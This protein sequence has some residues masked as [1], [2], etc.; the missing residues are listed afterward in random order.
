MRKRIFL[1][2]FFLVFMAV[3]AQAQNQV[4]VLTED[5]EGGGIP[6][7]WTVVDADGDGYNWNHSTLYPV[8][9]YVVPGHNSSGSLYSESFG[10]ATMSSLTPDNWLISPS[11]SLSGSSTLTYWVKIPDPYYTG[12]HYG[13]YVSTAV[14]PT[15]SDFTLLMEESLPATVEEWTMRTIL[16][17]DYA[18]QTVHIAFRHFNCS[19]QFFVLLDDVTVTTST[20]AQSLVVSPTSVNFGTV[21]VGTLSTVESVG[22]SSYNIT[23][24][25]AAIVTPPF[26]ISADGSQFGATLSMPDT[27][28]TFYVR[29]LPVTVGVDSGTVTI[30]AGTQI[31]T[32]TLYGTGMDCNNITLPFEDGF[33]AAE[34]NPCWTVITSDP[35]NPTLYG[36]SDQYSAGGYKSLMLLPL[37]ATTTPYDLYLITP[38][39]PVSGMKAVSFDHRGYWSTETFVVGYSTTTNDISAFTWGETVSSPA[40][41]TTWN[42]YLNVS[43]PGNA[44]YVAVHHTSSGGIALMLDNFMVEETSSCMAPLNL[45]VTNITPYSADLSWY[46]TSDIIDVT[47]YYVTGSDTNINEIPSVFLTDGVYTFSGLTPGDQYSW[48][49]GV[50]CDGDTLFSEVSTFA[51]P[52]EPIDTLP[53]VQDFDSVAV[54]SIPDCWMQLNPNNGFPKVTTSHALSGKALEFRC[55]Y[56]TDEPV[57]AVMPQFATDLSELQVSFWTRREG[58]S[59]GTLKVGYLTDLHDTASFVPVASFSSAQ[60][61]DNN[62][63][64]Y[65]VPF[66]DVVAAAGTVCYIA[67]KYETTANWFWFLDDVTV[68]E[69]PD[70]MVPYDLT[71]IDVTDNSA[72][73]SWTGNTDSYRVYYKTNTDTSWM[74]L[75]NA[76]LDSLNG[77]TIPNL[78]PNTN[79]QW[80]VAAVCSDSTTVNSNATST[81]KTSCGVYA[82]PFSET[83]NAGSA[84][85]DCWVRYS[86][87]AD[88]TVSGTPLTSTTSGWSFSNTN[89]LGQHHASLH[90]YNTGCHY[91]L[92]T[93]NID[94]DG[95][96]NPMLTFDLALTDHDNASV[97]ENPTDQSDDKFMVLF[98]TDNGVSWSLDDAVIWSND[99]AT[100]DYPFNSIATTGQTVSISLNDYVGETVRIAFYGESTVSNGDND[101]HVDN[102]AIGEPPQCVAP[103]LLN[104]SNVT[105][106]TADISWTENGSATAWLVEYGPFYFDPG[107]GT[108]IM[109]SDTPFVM[110]TNLQDNT[111]YRVDVSALCLDGNHSSS[112]SQYFTTPLAPSAIPYSTDFSAMSD[113]N[114]LINNGSGLNWWT[115]GTPYGTNSSA[116]YVTCDYA[117]QPAQYNVSSTSVISAVK[118]L[119]VG[120]TEEVRISFDVNIGGEG[121]FDFI[122]LFFAPD[123]MHYPAN[124]TTYNVDYCMPSYSMFAYDFTDYLSYSTY[125]QYPFK[126]NLTDGNT[127]HIDAVMPNP[128]INPT[129]TSVAHLA[130]L[131]RNDFMSG[132]QPGAIISNL[133][134]TP[135]TCRKPL[136]LAVSS[137]TDS[138]A[139]ISWQ[140]GAA[141]SAWNIQYKTVTDTVWTTLSATMPTVTLIGL[142]PETDYNVR[143]QADCGA[144][145]VSVYSYTAFT[146]DTTVVPVILPTVVTGAATDIMQTT[147]TLHAT[148]TNPDNVTVSERGFKVTDVATGNQTTITVEGEGNVYSHDLTNLTPSTEYSVKAFITLSNDTIIYGDELN[149][150]TLPNQLPDTCARPTELQQI[151]MLKDG[152]SI[153]VCWTDNA[154]V[155]QWNLQYRP[156]NGDWVAVV[157]TGEPCYNITGLMD[158]AVYEIRVQAVCSADNLSEWSDVLTATASHSGF[159][160]HLMQRVFLYPNPAKEYIDIRVNDL[161]VKGMEVYDVYGKLINTVGVCDTPVQ[162]RINVSGLADGMYFVRVTTEEGV[163]TKTFVKR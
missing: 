123:T 22:V 141:E 49:L 136:N 48:M 112:V 129:S 105:T 97:V 21:N 81:F 155:N 5:F 37:Y 157:V 52:C 71:V 140:P 130:F 10:A 28:G 15:V 154:G 93:P 56:M 16:L 85:P 45:E 133:S 83:F 68:E 51:T 149:F 109:V 121:S 47:L 19:D 96:A 127:V 1:F 63:H 39:L 90:I 158:S 24:N 43:V 144:G 70:C 17:D 119:T 50:I 6:S 147:A 117:L 142:L 104:V 108:T 113:Q 114:W 100:A 62:Y 101:L 99:P 25:V 132:T 40:V 146:T 152:A 163:V 77:C 69:I 95:L 53:Y 124:S 73:V 31:R 3:F 134:V 67:F 57:F 2:G 7:G 118:Y 54:N 86:G 111:E 27:G 38:E 120:T 122:K 35:L 138:S 32:V 139:T 137:V 59:S 148:I 58:A 103:S 135:V 162:T 161:N 44:K 88:E 60:L 159:D 145:D 110:L 143:V 61:G 13:V 64:Y 14:N 26:E 12:E 41:E 107:T 23:G 91:W 87:L 115:M 75:D 116:L 106:S 126:F 94:L 151:I 153:N 156:Q 131:W 160:N 74:V 18:G 46:Q 66:S 30:T 102:V 89:A 72:N 34:L 8:S 150:T 92:V 42:H 65:N 79:Y 76:I 55:D 84:L 80:Y 82:V 98:S 36:V 20:S 33:E 4:P 125:H 78:L 11:V 29:Y 128:Y 9:Y